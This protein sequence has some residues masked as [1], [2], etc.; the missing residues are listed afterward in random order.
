MTLVMRRAAAAGLSLL[1]AGC[2]T[3]PPP[4]VEAWIAAGGMQPP[5]QGECPG[6]ANMDLTRLARE[7]AGRPRDPR[8][9]TATGFIQ[10]P[11]SAEALIPDDAVVVI[12]ANLPATA[13]YQND[14]RAAVWKA[15][16]GTW[17]VWRQDRKLGEPP[18]PPPP[19]PP[20][21]AAEDSPQYRAAM[22]ARDLYQRTL[23]DPDL[24]WPPQTGRLPERT[25]RAIEA[26]LADPCRAYDPADF[27][28]AQP[29]RRRE[30]GSDSRM[31]PPGGSRYLADVTEQGRPRRAISAACINDTPTYQIITASANA[32]P[33]V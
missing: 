27:P 30:N 16:D 7:Q 25:A 23:R 1:V 11:P 32:E 24:R 17:S 18:P 6:V 20:P 14:V 8:D 12:R 33:E 22:E 29:L 28:F 19:P 4:Q 21:G 31:C 10:L 13:Q 2:Q 3:T 9:P 26:A 15:S 5:P